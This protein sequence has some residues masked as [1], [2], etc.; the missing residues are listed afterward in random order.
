[1]AEVEVDLVWPRFLLAYEAE[2]V[3]GE[4]T[5]EFA[6][7][8]AVEIAET[9]VGSAEHSGGL[10]VLLWYP[11]RERGTAGESQS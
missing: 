5:A 6:Q 1:M 7:E 8:S 11:G 9:G 10:V 4:L 2:K 3:T